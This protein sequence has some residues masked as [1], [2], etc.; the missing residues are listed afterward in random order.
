MKPWSPLGSSLQ[1]HAYSHFSPFFVPKITNP[2][3]HPLF[4]KDPVQHLLPI[5][6]LL[7]Q[8]CSLL[9]IYFSFTW[10][11][12]KIELKSHIHTLV[13]EYFQ[14]ANIHL[15]QLLHGSMK[16]KWQS[17]LSNHQYSE[18]QFRLSLEVL[19]FLGL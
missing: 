18:K 3:S 17:I 11:V 13:H 14:V 10:N 2:S 5:K 7:T 15:K 8:F 9:F 4:L 1:S 19:Y 6:N 16:R 12:Y